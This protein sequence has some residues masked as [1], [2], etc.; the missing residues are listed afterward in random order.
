[1]RN[2]GFLTSVS[3][4]LITVPTAAA[5]AAVIADGSTV[6]TMDGLHRGSQ[7]ELCSRSL[8]EWEKDNKKSLHFFW[9]FHLLLETFR[10][11]YQ[12]GDIIHQHD[13]SMEENPPDLTP[14]QNKHN[15]E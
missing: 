10:S 13:G 3:S 12:T 11:K 9:Y 4:D 7:C 1:M 2:V 14:E 6:K 5:A 8:D 15:E